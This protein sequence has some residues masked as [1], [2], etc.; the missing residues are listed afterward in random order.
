MS[1]DTVVSKGAIQFTND[2]KFAYAYSGSVSGN[3]TEFTVLEF[4]TNSEYIVGYWRVGYAESTYRNFDFRLLFNNIEIENQFLITSQAQS[5]QQFLHEIIIP[6][7][8]TVKVTAQNTEDSTTQDV[9]A[10]ITGKVGMGP[11]VGNLDD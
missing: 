10:I 8:T 9:L 1:G 3:N 11:R 6:P 4:N 5:N 2:N 7:F